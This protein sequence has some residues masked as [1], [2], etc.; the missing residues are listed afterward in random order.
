MTKTSGPTGLRVVV[1]PEGVRVAVSAARLRDACETVLRAERVKHA[2]VSLTL[3][4]PV[5]MA[6]MNKKHLRHA[7]ATDV[8]AFGFRDPDGAVLGD[9]Y[10]CPA[11]AARNAL[12]FGVSAREEL[13]RL[14]VHGTLHVLGHDHPPGDAR[15]SSPMWT[16]QERLLAK[17]LG[18]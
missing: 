14:A 17:V 9:V 5:R 4:T 7:G 18:A 6:A 16:M 1:N 8:I 15:I 3:L 12:R 13:L 10:V 2:L 11:V